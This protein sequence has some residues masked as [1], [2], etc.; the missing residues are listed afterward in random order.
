VTQL[1]SWSI[2]EDM[3]KSAFDVER[4]VAPRP[5]SEVI[6]IIIRMY[7]TD[8]SLHANVNLFLGDLLVNIVAKF[9]NGFRGIVSSIDLLQTSVDHLARKSHLTKRLRSIVL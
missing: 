5:I 2:Q 1:D 9:I 4:V 3:G 8:C 6:Q 7:S